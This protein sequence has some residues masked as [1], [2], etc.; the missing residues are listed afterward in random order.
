LTSVVIHYQELALKGRNRPWFINTLVRTIRVALKDLEVRSVTAVVGRIVVHLGPDTNWDEA[1]LRIARLPGIGNFAGATHVPPDLGAIGDGILARLDSHG[2]PS[3][4]A[5]LPGEPSADAGLPAEALAKAGS[6]RVCARRADK[7]FPFPSPDI[8]REIGRRIQQ[9]TGWPVD[10]SRPDR[11]IYVEVLT[12][13]A[14]FYFDKERGTGGL[15]VGTSG[16]VLCLLS[17]GIDSPVASWRMIRR[18]CRAHFVHFHS[19]PILSRTSQDKARTLVEILTKTQLKSR[20]YLVPFGGIQQRVVVSVP[21]PLRIVVYRRLMVRIAERFAR[22]AGIEALVTGD[23]VGQVASQT[24]ENITAIEG[25]ATMP[26]LR[27]LLGFDKEEITLEAQR[28]GTYE[29]SIIPD[30]DCCT[31]FTPRFPATRASRE[32]AEAAEANLDV[33]SLVEQAVSAAVVEDFRFP[34]VRSAVAGEPA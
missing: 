33:D 30:E 12:D 15:P 2:E 3:A 27:P 17:G 26:I 23:V 21:P 19:Y 32:D 4:D 9:Q 20:L 31:L 29:T 6:F 22:I 10:L 5:G 24:I 8:E 7:R 25:A 28:L 11:K 13:D 16:R 1:R 34:M 14:F 18:G